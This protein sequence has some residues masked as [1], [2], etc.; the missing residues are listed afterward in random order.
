MDKVSK[1]PQI[2][3]VV[4][5]IASVW[6][7]SNY[8]VGCIGR[9]LHASNEATGTSATTLYLVNNDIYCLPLEGCDLR[10]NNC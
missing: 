4:S 1:L 7:P 9:S 3:L 5:V 8:M 2:A 10:V 6:F